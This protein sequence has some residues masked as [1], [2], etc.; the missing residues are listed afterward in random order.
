[1]GPR[2]VRNEPCKVHTCMLGMVPPLPLPPHPSLVHGGRVPVPVRAR[3]AGIGVR[4]PQTALRD[5]YQVLSSPLRPSLRNP[6][7]THTATHIAHAADPADIAAAADAAADA[8]VDPNAEAASAAQAAVEAPTPTAAQRS[9]PHAHRRR[10]HLDDP[11]RAAAGPRLRA[12][13]HTQRDTL[14]AGSVP[15]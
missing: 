5:L 8:A 13:L 12:F 9:L 4:R 7:H 2:K 10:R 3:R 1:M 14:T 6:T 11:P 15:G